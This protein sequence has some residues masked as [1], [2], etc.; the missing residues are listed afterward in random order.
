MRVI[1]PAECSPELREGIENAARTFI[2][3]IV[4]DPASLANMT[5][6]N[7]ATS[8]QP[9]S[10]V[11]KPTVLM[12]HDDE[13]DEDGD[14]LAIAAMP[15]HRFAADGQA[16]FASR[17]C[18]LLLLSHTAVD[19]A[20]PDDKLIRGMFNSFLGIDIDL[21][22]RKFHQVAL[23]VPC[24]VCLRQDFESDEAFEDMKNK[25]E[26]QGMF[27]QMQAGD[28]TSPVVRPFASMILISY[29]PDAEGDQLTAVET[30]LLV[31]IDEDGASYSEV[32]IYELAKE[33][34][35]AWQA[36]NAITEG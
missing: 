8:K 28:L 36:S 26:R 18:K 7:F 32:D 22:L 35:D 12:T 31:E 20:G 14:T 24:G 13:P 33:A 30:E 3:D 21:P 10:Y 16:Q 29:D 17:A 1:T 34:S 4:L 11:P 23:L 25:G 6:T 2:E 9:N 27:R 15:A 5:W 19:I